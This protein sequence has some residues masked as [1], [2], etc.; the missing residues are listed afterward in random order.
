MNQP[1]VHICPLPPEPSPFSHPIH[2]SRLSQST[3]LISLCQIANSH[4]LS[5][6]HM[7]MCMFP[8]HFL[9]LPRPLPPHC[10]LK[11]V[12][13]VCVFIAALQIGSSVPISFYSLLKMTVLWIF[14]LAL[15]VKSPTHVF[16]QSFQLSV[17]T[18]HC[19]IF[20]LD[21]LFP[22]LYVFFGSDPANCHPQCL[23]TSR[24]NGCLGLCSA[25]SP[26]PYLAAAAG[27]PLSPVLSFHLHPLMGQ[28]CSVELIAFPVPTPD[29]LPSEFLDEVRWGGGCNLQRALFP[30]GSF[31]L[32]RVFPVEWAADRCRKTAERAPSP[33]NTRGTDRQLLSFCFG[34]N[35]DG[36]W[37]GTSWWKKKTWLTLCNFCVIK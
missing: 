9:N 33:I 23:S 19:S 8:C 24:G 12:L 18:L 4:W 32:H 20:L 37:T 3:G 7:V 31:Q 17:Y 27:P 13:Y 5:T 15:W 28:G 14:S 29:A 1:Q 16:S 35:T 11:S 26:P 21:F 30:G 36:L 10:V 25:W 2:P 6:L 34:S 22:P